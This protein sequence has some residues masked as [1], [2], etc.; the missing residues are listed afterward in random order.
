MIVYNCHI[1]QTKK[2]N[3]INMQLNFSENS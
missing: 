2:K 3:C 1:Y